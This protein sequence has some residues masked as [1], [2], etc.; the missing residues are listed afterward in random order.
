MHRP[1]PISSTNAMYVA[2]ASPF[3]AA[4][5]FRFRLL[6]WICPPHPTKPFAGLKIAAC[7]GYN[8]KSGRRERRDR[9]RH[10]R[11]I[12]G[13]ETYHA[14]RKE[15]RRHDTSRARARAHAQTANVTCSYLRVLP[16]KNKKRRERRRKT[17]LEEEHNQSINHRAPSDHD[18]CV[19]TAT[20]K[21]TVFFSRLRLR[22]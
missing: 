21:W 12:R 16:E 15:N 20:I 9:P 7:R 2:T 5:A 4:A 3:A 13:N 10:G 22:R 6:I 18:S 17:P 11:F 8:N 19:F 14:D 1:Q